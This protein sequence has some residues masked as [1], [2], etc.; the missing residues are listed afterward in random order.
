M[1]IVAPG[2]PDAR[3]ETEQAFRILQHILEDFGE[4]LRSV[5]VL[6][7]IE[8]M[9]MLEIAELLELPQGTVASRLRK[10]RQEFQRRVRQYH[11]VQAAQIARGGT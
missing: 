6:Y 2:S 7:E 9:T 1:T 4:E 10:A 5:F 3:L 8:E 11:T